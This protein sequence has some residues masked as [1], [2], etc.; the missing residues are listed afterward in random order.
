MSKAQ[1]TQEDNMVVVQGVHYGLIGLTALLF[2]IAGAIIYFGVQVQSD[3]Q[4]PVSSGQAP[5]H[6]LP[7][8]I[9]DTV[10]NDELEQLKP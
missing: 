10:P 5:T 9:V 4:S 6:A 7:D 1:Q 8:F 2:V 3:E